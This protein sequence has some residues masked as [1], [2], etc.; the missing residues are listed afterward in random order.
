MKSEAV[1]H[2]SIDLERSV[3]L[4][5]MRPRVIVV[6]AGFGGLFAAR[7][8]AGRAVDVVL[9]DRNNFHT[10]TPL[11]YQVATC[12]LDPS[13]VA[14]PIRSIFRNDTN[15]RFLLG[16]VT[17]IKSTDR[18]IMVSTD[19]GVF[20]EIY[21]YLILAAGSSTIYF[22]GDALRQH[23]FEL[24]SLADAVLLRNHILRLFERAAWESDL[25]Q[26]DA[27][28][29]LVVVGGGPTG[30]ETA[31]AL[32]ELYNHVLAK[33]YGNDDLIKA[34]VVLI[35]QQP[36]ILG[37]F[38]PN[39]REAALA[40]LESL[41]VEVILDS[42]ITDLTPRQVQLQD[43]KL[44]ETKTVVWAAGVGASTVAEMLQVKLAKRNTVPVEQTME[45]IGHSQIYAVGDIAY[46]EDLA[47]E[48]YPMFIPVAKQQGIVAAK[49]ILR[50]A[51]GMSQ[52]P[53]KF[54]DRG[55]MATIGRRRAVAW[56]YNRLPLSGFVAWL[57]WLGLHLVT[58]MGFRNQLNVLVNWTWNYFTYD[59]SVRII[60]ENGFNANGSSD[61]DGDSGRV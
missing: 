7:Y 40:Q 10:F 36:D 39:L 20:E 43:G 16:E 5:D 9:I 32:Y 31:G 51:E 2:R 17:E 48:P 60:L 61:S 46:L 11:L 59:R 55:I 47:A 30:V 56:I 29:T 42:T 27:M 34:R 3:K 52:V 6:G 41:G 12:V 33:E 24:K 58:L 4:K 25:N 19:G 35:E 1:L 54:R 44:I 8:L 57:A 15:V 21:D 49:N 14:F 38:P 22:N 13:E 26:R 50:H 45:V 18:C 28:T 23:S 37:D 53:F